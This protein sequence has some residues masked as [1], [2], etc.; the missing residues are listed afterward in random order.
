M[1]KRGESLFEELQSLDAISSL[2][3]KSEQPEFECK[4]WHGKGS[5]PSI[6]EAVCGMANAVG[7]VIL[8]GPIAKKDKNA[9]PDD[10]DVIKEVRPVANCEG[11]L[12]EIQR[13]IEEHLR[14][15]LV[16]T[17]VTIPAK[18]G[19]ASGYVLLYIPEWDGTPQM[20]EMAGCSNFYQRSSGGTRRMLYYQIADR[21]GRRPRPV[22]E[23]VVREINMKS[24]GME[25]I[26]P[27]EIIVKNT[28][29]GTARYPSIRLQ[30]NVSFIYAY[31]NP[32]IWPPQPGRADGW[33]SFRGGAD[34]VIYPGDVVKVLTASQMGP[35]EEGH[36]FNAVN[37]RAEVMAA[38]VEI[39]EFAFEF[40]EARSFF[41]QS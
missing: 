18:E 31:Q 15:G 30:G 1:A 12:S 28:G 3:G 16:F 32:S 39:R 7:G 9:G 2:V 33:V 36:V 17:P 10:F 26:R 4:S 21:F 13:A 25:I 6:V 19:E 27:F 23:V 24:L 29:R 40:G 35:R 37:I 11:V 20:V 5:L 14:P 41:G 34:E 8:I 22:L 38:E